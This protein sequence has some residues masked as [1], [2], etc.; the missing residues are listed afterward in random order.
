MGK[1]CYSYVTANTF[2]LELL[3]LGPS[4]YEDLCMLNFKLQNKTKKTLQINAL[5]KISSTK[6]H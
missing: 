2:S 5:L 6:N 1:K 3:C 4:V